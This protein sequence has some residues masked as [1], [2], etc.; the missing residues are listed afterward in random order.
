MCPYVDLSLFLPRITLCCAV[1][2]GLVTCD[3]QVTQ[4]ALI[5]V[6]F[7]FIENKLISTVSNR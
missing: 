3:N 5:A 4:G 7:V 6:V 1:F 2:V